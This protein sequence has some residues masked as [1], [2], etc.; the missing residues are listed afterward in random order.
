VEKWTSPPSSAFQ[1]ASLSPQPQPQITSP[2]SE[3]NTSITKTG[4][5]PRVIVSGEGGV[6]F[7]VEGKGTTAYPDFPAANRN[8][9]IEKTEVLSSLSVESMTLAYSPGQCQWCE[10]FSAS[11]QELRI[12]T[13]L[14]AAFL[15]L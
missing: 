10:T 15:R 3:G 4:A 1:S 11:I 13:F 7:I 9:T 2:P 8:I 12:L 6:D 5:D 14:L